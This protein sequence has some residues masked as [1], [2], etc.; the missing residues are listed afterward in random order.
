MLDFSSTM[1][2]RATAAG[3]FRTRGAVLGSAL[4]VCGC[5][6]R[7]ALDVPLDE[8]CVP[9]TTSM[10]VPSTAPWF[11]TGIDVTA[12]DHLHITATGMVRYGVDPEQITDADG[13]HYTGTKFFTTAVLPTTVVVS[14]TGKVGGT[15]A[16]DTGTLL[17]EGTPDNGPGF[18][19]TS[20]DEIVPG[21]GRLFL[22]FNDRKEAFGDNS[23]SFTVTITLSC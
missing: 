4:L 10:E 3:F 15:T 18:V 1:K 2:P 11:D 17:L 16:V 19:G 8:G 14:L 7:S 12:G 20:Y 22:G 21:S 6:A 9:E 13:G 23:G 5:G